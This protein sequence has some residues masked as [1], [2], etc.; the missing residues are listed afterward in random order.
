MRNF[1]IGLSIFRTSYNKR[2]KARRIKWYEELREER[3][4]DIRTEI[5]YICDDRNIQRKNRLGLN[6]DC[7]G[8]YE[9]SYDCSVVVGVVTGGA[10][11]GSDS[12]GSGG[13]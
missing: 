5:S 11:G 13:D 6:P 4:K 10:A 9:I 1:A 7:I 8:G 3:M 12:A 2:N